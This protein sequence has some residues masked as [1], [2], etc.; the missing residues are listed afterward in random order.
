MN[1]L[2]VVF[3]FI[4]LAMAVKFFS[5]A[6]LVKQWHLLERETFIAVW[7]AIGIAIVLY[8]CG[9]IRFPHDGKPKFTKTRLFFIAL[10]SIITIYLIPGVTNTPAARLRLISGFPPPFSYSVYKHPVNYETGVEPLRDYEK[11]LQLAR[12]QH[13]PILIDFTG[14]A[15]VNCRR[16][17]E[18]VWV[19]EEVKSMMKNDFIVVSL[20][21][22]ERKKLP[23]SEQMEYKM[24]NGTVK[25][26]VTVGDKWATFQSENFNSVSQPQYA[27]INPDEIA[28]TKT[29]AYTPDPKAFANWL[30]CGLEAYKQSSVGS[31]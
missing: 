31:R 15:C 1:E 17:E 16:M 23:A 24:K 3:G 28:L 20:Y 21:V 26:I 11:A 12:E 22:D 7:I 2:K 18:S 14:W 25:P 13:K 29:K 5:N 4:E 6:D 8:L 27:I 30:K 19:K 9:V 10:F